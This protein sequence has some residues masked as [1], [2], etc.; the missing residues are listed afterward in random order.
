MNPLSKLKKIKKRR[1]LV[2]SGGGTQGGIQCLYISIK[3]N[4]ELISHSYSPYPPK[5]ASLIEQFNNNEGMVKISDLA[6]LDYK[7]SAL[8]VESAKTALM[9]TPSALR[10]PH[11]IVLDKP[12]IW[13]GP[14]GENQQQSFWD[15]PV[16]DAQFLAS[17]FG[18]PVITDFIRHNTIAGGNGI[19]PTDPGD[20][21]IASRCQGITVFINV[22]EICQMT[23]TDSVTSSIL[24]DSDCGPGSCT[25]NKLI[26]ELTNNKDSFDRDGS[27]AAKGKVD[28]DCLNKLATSD[29]FKKASPKYAL[30]NDFDYLLHDPALKSLSPEDQAATITALTARAAYDFYRVEYKQKITPQAVFISGGAVNNLTLMDYLK[31]YFQPIPV[32]SIEELGIPSDMKI[33]LALGITADAQ[34]SGSSIPWECGNNP[35]I[36]PMGRWVLP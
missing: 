35:K 11:Y 22:G 2:I 18:V 32:H 10:T 29:W 20:K 31:T 17:T 15:F 6:Y 25:I 7:I 24:T 1:V 30:K 26:K 21:I 19:L 12:I 8:F 3:G 4:W 28:G 5:I 27:F 33:S 14:S 16:G 23:V 34:I 9:Q 36:N 13:K